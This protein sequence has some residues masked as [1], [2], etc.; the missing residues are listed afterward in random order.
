[1]KQFK[2]LLPV[3]TLLALGVPALS[4]VDDG[5]DGHAASSDEAVIQAQRYSYPLTKCP[6]SGKAFGGDV[7]A[8]TFVHEGRL[9]LTCCGDCPAAIRKDPAKYAAMIDEAVIAQQTPTYPLETCVV[10]SEGLHDMG[11]P[12]DLVYGT[13]LVRLCCK[14]CKKGFHKDPEKFLAKIDA[15]L[16]EAQ[17]ADY[18]FET[19]VVS[20]EKLGS[21]GEPVDKLYGTTLVRFCC[22]GCIKT[23]EKEPDGFLAT[24]RGARAEKG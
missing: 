9:F 12:V 23:F 19:C 8:V 15:K 13:R 17:K 6:V 7:K 24:I 16:I 1:M 4:T 18:P 3:V 11:E 14:G 20:Q 21:M 22:K 5:H 2:S 10:S